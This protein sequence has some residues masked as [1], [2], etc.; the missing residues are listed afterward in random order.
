MNQN[1]LD[2][3]RYAV[4]LIPP[5]DVARHVSEIHTMLR[6]QFGLIAAG[7]FQVH[8]TLKG[9]FKISTEPLEPLITS[10]DSIFRDRRAIPIHFNGFHID[11]VG[12]GLDISRIGREPN[13]ELE[14]LRSKI[15]GAV[16]PYMAQDCDFAESDL[17]NPFKAHITL[18]FRDISPSRRESVLAYLEQAPLPT[19]PFIANT[20]HLLE[21]SSQEWDEEWDRSLTWR[22]L[23]SWRAEKRN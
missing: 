21:F 16:L 11:D 5:Y 7:K 15:V 18:A 4:Y 3:H 19:E 22:L 23:Y 6:K 13:R 9:F 14:D 12:I 17:G 2:Q 1:H 8:A 10:L 20:Y